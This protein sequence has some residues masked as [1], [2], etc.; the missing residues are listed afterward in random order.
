MRELLRL[1]VV[2]EPPLL[3]VA[4]RQ[5]PVGHGERVLGVIVRVHRSTPS[6][7]PEVRR[8]GAR[9]RRSRGWRKGEAP[10][11]AEGPPRRAQRGHLDG[12][13]RKTSRLAV[14]ALHGERHR[15]L[16]ERRGGNL[17][18]SR[19][20]LLAVVVLAG[21]PARVVLDV[22]G[23]RVPVRHAELAGASGHRRRPEG[24]S[25]ARG[26]VVRASPSE[27]I[28]SSL[29]LGAELLELRVPAPAR[30]DPPL[31]SDEAPDDPGGDDVVDDHAFGHLD[32]LGDGEPHGDALQERR[33]VLAPLGH[34]LLHEVRDQI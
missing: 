9:R 34:R 21:E 24:R 3:V 29:E 14:A 31:S 32:G 28:V 15:D 7:G 33:H 19:D 17:L 18:L 13:A 26:G 16:V 5:R 23:V 6:T 22:L 1:L 12:H 11:R 2:G 25:R 30:L 4:Y 8:T 20:S 10:R 27:G